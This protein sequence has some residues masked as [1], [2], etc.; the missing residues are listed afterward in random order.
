MNTEPRYTFASRE[1]ATAG[2]EYHTDT[3]VKTY[4]DGT[5]TSEVRQVPKRSGKTARDNKA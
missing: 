3:Y 2:R 5:M 4:P 1:D